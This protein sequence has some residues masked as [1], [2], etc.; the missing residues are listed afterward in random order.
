VDNA[1]L[2]RNPDEA[3]MAW[4]AR[5]LTVCVDGFLFKHR[6]LF[7]DR[8]IKFIQKFEATL[9]SAGVEVV[10]TPVMAPNCNVFAECFVL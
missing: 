1:A 8:D 2:T 3:F 6:C 10:L 4:I 9:K 5:N 7:C